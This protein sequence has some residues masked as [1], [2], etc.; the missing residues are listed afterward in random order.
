[1]SILD[2]R[3]WSEFKSIA[4]LRQD[5]LKYSESLKYYDLYVTCDCLAWHIRILK[6]TS[7]A[8]DF[9]TNYKENIRECL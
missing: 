4:E 8:I 1:M 2:V 3:T 9:E 6:N 5:N 7:D